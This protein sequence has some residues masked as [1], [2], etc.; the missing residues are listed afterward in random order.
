MTKRKG[1]APRILA[2]NR[3]RLSGDQ[4]YTWGQMIFELKQ[5]QSRLNQLGTMWLQE[6][7]YDDKYVIT[8]DGYIVPRAELERFVKDSQG[9]TRGSDPSSGPPAG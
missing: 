6:A 1:T 5:N 4:L 9:E 2:S 3:P 8:D 7:G